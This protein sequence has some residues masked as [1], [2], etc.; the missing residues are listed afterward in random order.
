[1]IAWFIVLSLA[2]A[3]DSVISGQRVS[4]HENPNYVSEKLNEYI[5]SYN[6]NVGQS[7]DDNP[8]APLSGG[9]SNNSKASEMAKIHWEQSI[10]N[11]Q[12]NELLIT[13][14]ASY[15][16]SIE[17]KKPII[18]YL[19]ELSNLYGEDEKEK[20]QTNILTR[21]TGN[22]TI[23]AGVWLGLMVINTLKSSPPKIIQPVLKK[24]V[25]RQVYS[26]LSIIWNRLMPKNKKRTK[27]LES[28]ATNRGW[29][30][31]LVL[32][33][34]TFIAATSEGLEL[35]SSAIKGPRLDPRPLVSM[36]LA[37]DAKNLSKM[38][39]DINAKIK[40]NN[41]EDPPSSMQSLIV[42]L[43]QTHAFLDE[44][45]KKFNIT[46]DPITPEL[47]E[48]IDTEGEKYQDLENI[49]FKGVNVS[50]ECEKENVNLGAVRLN[51]AQ[52]DFLLQP[53]L[54]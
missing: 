43:Q 39:C 31:A 7:T 48:K 44:Y 30:F 53:Q 37:Y 17:N 34:S 6:H 49:L 20:E 9:M 23:P 8:Y 24:P 3:Q 26:K 36:A 2:N 15:N 50:S 21:I 51:L 10:S 33:T 52:A 5:Q 11:E 4:R 46:H 47:R 40:E 54:N 29:Q 41:F 18:E 42:H 13:A 16:E 1:M 25:V 32:G 35:L 14:L 27:L 19:T 45:S 12:Y 38:S 28:I 22:Y